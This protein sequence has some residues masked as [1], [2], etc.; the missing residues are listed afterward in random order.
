MGRMYN[1]ILK[2]IFIIAEAGVNH[3]GKL[4]L[5]KKLALKAKESGAD[6]VKFQTWRTEDII[7][8][9]TKS[10][11]YQKKNSRQ[12]QYEIAKSLELSFSEFKQLQNY[13]K[14]IN[15][16]FVSTPDDI[17]SAKF[18]NNIQPFFKIGSPEINNFHLLNVVAKFR[19]PILLSTGLSNVKEI[20]KT[21]NFLKK[22]N[23]PIKKKLILMHCNSAYP[24]SK[25]D[26]NLSAI[27]TLRKK[28]NVMI[29]FSDH[30]EGIDCSVW[31]VFLNSKVIEK[32]IT[33]S[34]KMRGP[35]HVSSLD[36]VEF[37]RMVNKIREAEIAIGSGKKEVSTSAKR[38][39]KLMM[40]SIYAKI[41]VFKGDAFTEKNIV[42]KRPAG[43]IDPTFFFK[44]IG[45]KAKKNYQ[46]N[47]RISVIE[48]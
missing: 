39:K 36:P 23:F 32:H 29:G 26:V 14:K 42:T 22:I 7:L 17:K 16:L 28:F 47:D 21:I 9:G 18:L 20:E 12:N 45:K 48:I 46:I 6:A 38:N 43:G 5:A 8:P 41:P 1:K 25:K 19:K 3:N 27:N 31:S 30:T 37:K 35:D 2:R 4:L 33:I 24:T 15:I 10:L 34:K 11:K 44:L 13:C 40:R